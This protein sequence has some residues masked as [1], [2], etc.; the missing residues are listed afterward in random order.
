MVD[1][2]EVRFLVDRESRTLVVT[3]ISRVDAAGGSPAAQGGR[4][5]GQW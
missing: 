5:R 4:S 1:K 3:E 2:Y